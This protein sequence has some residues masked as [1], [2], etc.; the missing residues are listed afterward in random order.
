MKLFLNI[1]GCVAVVLAVLGIV[2]P[3]L[4]TTPFLLLAAA[5]FLRGSQ[6]LHRWLTGNRVFGR[7]L[8]DYQEK[9]GVTLRVKL[10]AISVM[11]ASMLY[12]M[13]VVPSAAMR[14][15]LAL[16]GA[17]VTV[18]LIWGLKT[19]QTPTQRGSTPINDDSP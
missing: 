18:Y 15:P 11:W 5:C 3:L 2:L 4:P 8:L 9:K 19:L 1:V 12:S 14:W 13:W 10:T 6:R 17:G 16:I 7:Y